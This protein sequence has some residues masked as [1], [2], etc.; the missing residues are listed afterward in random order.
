MIRAVIFDMDDTLID[1]SEREHDWLVTTR[2]CLRPVHEHLTSQGH[3]ILALDEMAHLYGEQARNAWEKV[4]PPEWACP[5]QIDILGNTIKALN[6][7]MENL[8][9]EKMQRL[10]AW[11]VIPGVRLFEDTIEVLK[12]LR[13]AGLKLGLVTNADLPM[14]MRD[15]ELDA[16]GLVEMIDV[17]LT[18]GDVGHLKPHPAPFNEAAKQLG[19]LPEEAVF[20][21]DRLQDDVIGAR[22]AGMRAVWIRRA[23]S[24][25]YE[26]DQ[27]SEGLRPNATIYKLAE[28]LTTF[29]LWYPGWRSED[30]K[31]NGRV[32][33]SRV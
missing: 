18:A 5:R 27:G 12:A 2:E 24:S 10:Y 19:I 14:W 26:P 30:Q 17:R 31:E 1:W 7:Q 6:I 4:A 22:T 3:E 13:E 33:S 23:S 15:L 9:I 16:F 28:L 20:V 29:D 21:G 8:D 11:K 32:A 25:W